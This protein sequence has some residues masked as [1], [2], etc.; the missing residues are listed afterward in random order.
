MAPLS[1][2]RMEILF[3]ALGSSKIIRDLNMIKAGLLDV[4]VAAKKLRVGSKGLIQLQNFGSEMEKIKKNPITGMGLDQ[5]IPK[6]KKAAAGFKSIG[7]V[8]DGLNKKIKNSTKQMKA[9]DMRFLS[10]LFTGMM[11]QR[12]FTKALTSIKNSFDKAENNSSELS[13]STMGLN[14]AWEFLKFSI[15]NAL[16]QP[17]FQR[18]IQFLIKTINW[19]S[20]LVNRIEWLGPAIIIAFGVFAVGGFLMSMIG[21]FGL[22]WMAV[23]G[24]FGLLATST[25]GG[26][27][28]ATASVA[29]GI[30]LISRLLKGMFLFYLIWDGWKNFKEG[31]I[32]GMFGAL[33]SGAITWA[34]GLGYGV[35]FYL[36]F[37]GF[38]WGVPKLQDA[39]AQFKEVSTLFPEEG[40]FSRI[41]ES[42]KAAFT[43][44]EAVEALAT[45]AKSLESL[46]T[47]FTSTS[48]NTEQ[49]TAKVKAF[50]EQMIP[51]N[52]A[53]T[54][55]I[56]NMS[57]L[58]T[59]T[60][61]NTELTM[62]YAAEIPLETQEH[63]NNAEAIDQEAQ[64]LTRLAEARRE[65]SR[66]AREVDEL[67]GTNISSAYGF[68]G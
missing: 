65:L 42:L 33:A 28:S 53:T 22:F 61:N 55:A 20:G 47:G 54:T 50:E 29:G 13:K 37:K 39:F 48:R 19:V 51:A 68:G 66:A 52:E 62:A 32:A 7:S 27:A 64:A 23:F 2:S 25:A 10:L 31:D 38:E 40:L 44:G 16:D 14:A 43:G 49:F 24:P 60:V 5:L 36:V 41:G 45:S 46:N 30:G 21:Q 63:L 17:I 1:Q 3:K 58:G 8:V 12:V 34:A 59:E 15:F 11:I 35:L 4:D 26:V 18:M 56:A 57:N 9:F 6:T 67:G